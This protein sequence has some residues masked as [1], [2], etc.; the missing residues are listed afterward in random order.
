MGRAD[1]YGAEERPEE[2][3]GAA[4]SGLLH[5]L[6]FRW[7]LTPAA[8]PT[9]GP[10]VGRESH[11]ALCSFVRRWEPALQWRAGVKLERN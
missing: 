8:N 10:T 9:P 1:A 4:R 3:D 6:Q 2:A 11:K 5:A 7:R